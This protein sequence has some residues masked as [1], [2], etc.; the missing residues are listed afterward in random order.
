MNCDVARTLIPEYLA[1]SLAR[2]EMLQIQAHTTSC[3]NC[4][5]ELESLEQ[6]WRTLGEWPDEEPDERMSR[7]FY[8]MLES[9]QQGIQASDRG[10]QP[11]R[12]PDRWFHRVSRSPLF[13]AVLAAATL[14]LGLLLGGRAGGPRAGDMDNLRNDLSEMTRLVSLSLMEKE[15][16]ADRLNGVRYVSRLEKPDNRVLDTLLRILENDS[17]VNVRLSA[18]EALYHLRDLPE[19]RS[20]LVLS[21]SRQD[22]ALVQSALIDCLVAINT[23]DAAE[24]LEELIADRET[25][26]LVKEKAELGLMEIQ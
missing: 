4:Y 13:P 20:G 3:R 26:P 15:S 11:V 17:S 10:K 9:F 18:A 8:H 12:G 24:S 21:L 14:M 16:A 7:N 22:S 2:G 25:D 1:G 23:P 6:T 5:A 19:V